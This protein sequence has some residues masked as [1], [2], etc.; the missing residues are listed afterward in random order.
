M[1]SRQML[2]KL[3]V[4]LV[5]PL[6]L[7]SCQMLP[8]EKAAAT[9]AV[10]IEWKRYMPTYEDADT[11]RTKREIDRAINVYEAVCIN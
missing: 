4:L 11:E 2:K 8:R 1:R 9:E 10:C 5:A 6:T 3:L 7:A